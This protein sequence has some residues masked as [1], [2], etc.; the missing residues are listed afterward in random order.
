MHPATLCLSILSLFASQSVAS[1]FVTKSMTKLH[2]P[3]QPPVPRRSSSLAY[4][5]DDTTPRDAWRERCKLSPSSASSKSLSSFRSS[6]ETLNECNNP[7]HT[8][9]ILT[10]IQ[11]APIPD[12]HSYNG[13]PRYY[14]HALTA[15]KHAAEH[16]EEEQVQCVVNLGD[17]IDG[18]CADVQ[19]HLGDEVQDEKKSEVISV[20]HDAIDDVLNALSRYKCGRILHTYG[21]H[22]LYNLAREGLAEKLGIPFTLEPTGDLV[23]YYTHSIHSKQHNLQPSPLKSA[24]NNSSLKL[25]FLVIDS[26]DICLLDRCPDTSPK[27]KMAHDILSKNNHNYPRD[28]NSPEGLEGLS[29]RFVAFNGG[30]DEPQLAWLEQSLQSAKA[31]GEKVIVLSHQPIH[32]C[33]TFPTCLIWNY[34]DVLSILRKYS[35]VVIAS[36]SGHAHKGGYIRD[37][38][39]GIHFRTLEAV[40]ESADPIRTY[41]M[42]DIWEDRMVVRGFGDCVSDEYDLNHLTFDSNA[43]LKEN[44]Q[45]VENDF[46]LEMNRV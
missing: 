1:A 45:E 35:N 6:T 31:N 28:E 24:R 38:E 42:V 2:H 27:R 25:R 9:G 19:Q 44:V 15:A 41:A 13:T 3:S 29:K 21:N 20:S 5:G 39:S 7:M 17:I 18:K 22:E 40:L 4:D 36:F 23:G 8:F 32:P 12:G 14:R 33:S 46:Q 10:D 34:E 26:Y 37:E 16:F 30:V 11:H 43:V